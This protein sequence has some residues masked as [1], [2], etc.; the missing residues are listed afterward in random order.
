MNKRKMHTVTMSGVHYM[1]I[2][3][4]TEPYFEMAMKKAKQMEEDIYE[5]GAKFLYPVEKQITAFC[6]KTGLGR[7]EAV[8]DFATR[9]EVYQKAIKYVKTIH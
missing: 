7:D 2:N 4:F 9:G 3:M 5:P 8:R 6:K 1:E